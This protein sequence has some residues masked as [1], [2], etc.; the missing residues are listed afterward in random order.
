[1]RDHYGAEFFDGKNLLEVG[2]GYGDIG[3]SFVELGALV[4]CS[5]GR[6]SHMKEVRRRHRAVA[7]VQADLDEPW[8]FDMRYDVL[9]HM[10]V[11]YH[12]ADPERAM[13]VMLSAA[14]R[15]FGRG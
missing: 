3:A 7:A 1:M 13:H 5:D 2:C 10:G 6:A 14:R 8:P 4:T 12:L 15:K 9:I 11:L